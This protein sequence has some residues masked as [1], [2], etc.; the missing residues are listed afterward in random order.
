MTKKK[1]YKEKSQQFSK[2]VLMVFVALFALIPF[3]WMFSSAFRPVPE[4]FEF[5]Y[6]LSWKTFFPVTFTADNFIALLF[7]KGSHWPRYILNT[8]FVAL[9]TVAIGSLVNA[10]A[11]YA[12]ARLKFPG[13]KV[14]FGAVLLTMI[15]P[16]E[17]IAIPL[18]M[19]VK[20]LG[21][22]DTYQALILPAL[23]NGF[24][25]FLLRQFFLGFP[26][27]LE[28]AAIIDGASNIGIFFKIVIPLSWPVMISTGLLTFQASW[29]SF[30]WPLIV[31]NSPEKRVVQIGI[32]NLIGSDATYWN[33][34]F[35][36]VAI[37]AIVPLVIFFIF[38]RYYIQGIS[39]TGLKG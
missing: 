24:N 23:A 26:K 38:Q 3:I 29:D 12:F 4:I 33:E 34:L 32:S 36:A 10:L 1:V 19:V 15:I 8:L 18:Y 5:V 35:A 25:I 7:S 17:A 20:Q 11:A 27:E 14:L 16:F 6:P 22:V 28:E 30:I 31:T 9:T 21:W 37:G 2:F 13:K 39:T